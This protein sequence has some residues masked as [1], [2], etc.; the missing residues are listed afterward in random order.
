M[1]EIKFTPWEQR[2]AIIDSWKTA[3][4]AYPLTISIIIYLIF[5]YIVLPKFMKNREPFNIN[6]II[7]C[8]NVFL[9]F[10]CFYFVFQFRKY[11]LRFR[12]TWQCFNSFEDREHNMKEIDE[13]VWWFTMLRLFEFIETVFFILRKKFDQVSFLHVYHHIGTVV[14]L[15]LFTK[16]NGGIMGIYFGAINS[17]IHIIMYGYYLISSFENMRKFSNLIKPFLTA[18]QITQLS[19]LVGQ[20]ISAL[21]PSCKVPKFLFIIQGLN[22]LYLIYMFSKFFIKS[23]MKGKNKKKEMKNKQ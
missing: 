15:Y 10:A 19:L 5:V 14:C 21:R 16:H 4:N 7:R 3:S 11:G 17:C 9:I 20:S 1:S 18:I 2:K 8:Y 6:F 23:F 22:V 12:R 13:V